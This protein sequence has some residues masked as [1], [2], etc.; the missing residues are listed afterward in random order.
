VHLVGRSAGVSPLALEGRAEE[1]VVDD[2]FAGSVE[3]LSFTERSARELCEGGGGRVDVLEE[4]RGDLGRD[5]GGGERG[6]PIPCGFR[7]AGRREGEAEADGPVLAREGGGVFGGLSE[8]G[9]EGRAA[10]EGGEGGR[11]A[12]ERGFGFDL[13]EALFEGWTAPGRGGRARG[14]HG[15]SCRRA[16]RSRTAFVAREYRD[17][18]REMQVRLQESEYRATHSSSL[19]R[20]FLSLSRRVT[21]PIWS[22]RA[23]SERFQAERLSSARIRPRS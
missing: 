11:G 13:A 9:G 20:C 12:I 4:G 19:R 6:A 15:I 1:E 18:R 22:R 16:L 21:L 23:V 7:A 5:A 8:I 10:R 3:N 2:P 14:V 17:Q